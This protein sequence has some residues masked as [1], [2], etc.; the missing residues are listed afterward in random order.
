MA[1]IR[2]VLAAEP[3]GRPGR[4]SEIDSSDLPDGDVTVRV[5]W[6]SLNYKDGLAVTGNAKVVRRFPMVCGVDL[7]GVVEQSE[8]P[9]IA[10]GQPV[11]VTGWGL[12]EERHGGYADVARVQS[13]WV[14]AL[15][16]GLDLR[17]A[18]AI[19]TAG[20]TSMLCVLSLERHG[21]TPER[22]AGRP[23]VVT[24]AAGGVGSVAVALLAQLGY[25]VTAVSGRPEQEGYLRELGASEVTARS[26]LA[27]AKPRALES[28]QWAGAVDSVGGAVLATILRQ[29]CY[30]GCVAAC[31]LAGGAELRT[32][33]HPFILRGVDLA[34]VDSVRCPTGVRVEAWRRLAVDLPHRLL[35]SLTVEAALEDVVSLAPQI[36]AGRTR[37]RVAI[38]VNP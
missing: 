28:E 21:L 31:G 1:L 4:L 38:A 3:D 16:E 6:S 27:D 32:T 34:G 12:G 2:A 37:G 7:A 13:N 14:V 18:M 33:V 24:G 29:T 9:G 36:L 19:G 26:D 8:A 20:L 30:G 22:A 17:R 5:H 23:I 35:D 25:R 15:P 10:P 11:I